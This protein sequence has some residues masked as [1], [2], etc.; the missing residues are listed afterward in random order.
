MKNWFQATSASSIPVS[1][2]LLREKACDVAA[3]LGIDN[4]SASNGWIDR[5][6]QQYN[7]VYKSVWAELIN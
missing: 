7:V 2:V 4:F 5:F 6:K 1:G 3:R